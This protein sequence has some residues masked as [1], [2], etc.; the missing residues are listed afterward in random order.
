VQDV[1]LIHFMP[2][3]VGSSIAVLEGNPV[4]PLDTVHVASALEWSADLFVSAD[5][6]QLTAA[7]RVGLRAREV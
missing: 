3:V 6:R 5:K 7:K 4:R 1:D 2:A